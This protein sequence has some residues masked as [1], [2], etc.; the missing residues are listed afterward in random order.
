MPQQ[1]GGVGMG[2]TGLAVGLLAVFVPV[3]GV[4]AVGLVCCTPVPLFGRLRGANCPVWPVGVGRWSVGRVPVPPVG[5]LPLTGATG[6]AV[7]LFL[8][9]HIQFVFVGGGGTIPNVG[10]W[11]VGLFQLPVGWVGLFLFLCW[12]SEVGGGWL[13]V[14]RVPVP[15]VGQTGA[16]LVCCTPVPCWPSVG[17]LFDVGE[18]FCNQL[19]GVCAVGIV[20][21][22][23]RIIF[24]V[25]PVQ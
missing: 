18:Y 1:A 6:L 23:I 25:C 12:P 8:F 22:Q 11:P 13:A 4:L 17:V 10:R 20:K 7:G 3:G 16:G 21:V 19:G 2:A 5:G 24:D 9:S 15:C 14:W